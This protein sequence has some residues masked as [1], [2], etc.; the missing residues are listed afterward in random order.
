MISAHR[1][2]PTNTRLLAWII[3]NSYG[4]WLRRAYR[5]EAKGLEF[6]Q[7]LEPPFV[8][9]G[10]H[11]TLLDPFLASA[12]IPRPIHWVASDGNM[13]N[14]L[15]RFLLIKIAGSIPKSKAIPDIETVNWIVEFIRKRK[16]IVGFYPEGQSSWNGSSLPSIGSTPK[17]LKLLKAPV[18]LTLTKGAYMT[19]PRWAYSNRV[20]RVEIEFSLLFRPDELKSMSVEMIGQ[21]LNE[22][23]SHDDPAWAKA[24]GIQFANPKRAECLEL[25]LYACPACGALQSLESKGSRLLCKA[26][27]AGTDY[28][29]DGSFSLPFPPGLKAWD[30]WQE[31]HLSRLLAEK[32]LPSPALPIFSDEGVILLSGRRMDTMRRLGLGSLVLNSRG[33]EFTPR[34]GRK[35]FFRLDE[36]DGPG[37]LKWNFFEFY[38]GKKVYRAKF[39]DRAASGRKY[40]VALEVLAQL[41][42][43]P[44]A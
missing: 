37:I 24:A 18:V 14:P 32:Y 25:F 42:K 12:F 8:V 44:G 9:V 36:I 39:K 21:R 15:M 7:S 13:R 17:L 30:E 2:T 43:K 33:L 22:A 38:V 26:C 10:N 11:S 4:A 5:A 20:G 34:L 29:E 40:A 19:M 23:I 6:V 16:G 1:Y 28:G 41:S 27:G 31:G 3:R 35:L